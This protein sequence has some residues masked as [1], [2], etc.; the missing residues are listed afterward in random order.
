MMGQQETSK[1]KTNNQW[2]SEAL[3]KSLDG[4]RCIAQ[5][6]PGV[7]ELELQGSCLWMVGLHFSFHHFPSFLQK[8]EKHI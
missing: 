4:P 2:G 1:G 6:T 5:M 3:R 8:A 7:R